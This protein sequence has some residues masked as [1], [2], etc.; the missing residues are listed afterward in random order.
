MARRILALD[1]GSYSLKA[2][3][4]ESTLRRS[5]V[6]G[7]FQQRRDPER[8]LVDQ[9]QEFRAAQAL[10]ADTTL[11]C[12][13]GDAVSLRF[14]ELPFTR[15]R[16]LEQTVPFEL[17][18]QLPFAPD[19]VVADFH[20]VQR[21][22]AGAT[23]LTVATPK[24]T[25]TEH[26]DMLAAAG[27][28]PTSVNVAAL[29]PLTF[30]QFAGIDLSGSTALLDIGVDRTTVLLL[31]DGVL[32]GLRVLSIGLNRT[33]GFPAFMRELQWTI[34]AFGGDT[35]ALPGRF[36][37]CGGG[38][39]ISRLREE[40]AQALAADII[41][42]H[43]L[44]LPLLSDPQRQEQGVYAVCLGLGLRE[45]L[46]L[47][48]PAVNLRQGMFVHQE[49]RETIRKEISRLAW[50]AAGAAA[51]AG[52]T[53][54]LEMYRLN[55]RHEALRQEIRQVFTTTVPEIQTIVSEKAQLQDALDT[56]HARQRLL[57][58]TTTVSPLELLRQLSAA[59]PDHVSLDLDEWT[60]DTDSVR[61][62]GATTSFDAAETVK[63]TVTGL[64]VFKDVQ[65]KD[66]KTTA[67]G[68]KVS[69]ALQMAFNQKTVS[70]GQ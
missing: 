15:S 38:S 60:F 70:S 29:P 14:L 24:I 21:T 59:M 63:T 44:S 51:A 17:S 64:G 53:F 54:G 16:Q 3:I 27:F 10:G 68:K 12:L 66:V 69:F 18:S 22:E 23:I 40:L 11:S 45:A 46:G 48:T 30:L 13:P 65:L 39:R 32:Q 7:L 43:E 8:S 62:K 61:L 36:F 55:T 42:F 26:L 52:L 58:G 6:L 50:L 37:L 28:N 56:L 19:A 31:R 5:R 47:T 57:Q 9:L 1:I 20:I 49:H 34:L 35:E 4:V 41:P 2:A 33:G 25:L 67:S